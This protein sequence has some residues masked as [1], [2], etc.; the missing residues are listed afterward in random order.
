M[1][2]DLDGIRLWF[3]ASGPGPMLPQG[4]T[5]TQR[6]ALVAVHGGPGLDHINMKQALAPLA[7]D[8]QIIFYD[9]RGHGRS[10][11]SRAEFWNLPTWAILGDSATHSG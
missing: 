1:L 2:L 8:V 6:P 11:H 4:E 3:D 7:D 9:Q 5:V 10:D